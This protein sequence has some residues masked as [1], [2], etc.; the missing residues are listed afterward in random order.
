M[1]GLFAKA[2]DRLPTGAELPIWYTKKP[3]AVS[4][5]RR[6]VQVVTVVLGQALAVSIS[7]NTSTKVLG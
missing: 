5:N 1:P 4:T 3:P 7:L 2:A 6:G